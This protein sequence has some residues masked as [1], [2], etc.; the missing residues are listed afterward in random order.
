LDVLV[1]RL[2]ESSWLLTYEG[3]VNLGD[4]S[5]YCSIR[6]TATGDTD[7]I[8]HAPPSGTY[9]DEPLEGFGVELPLPNY[10]L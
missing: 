9:C 3:W 2:D 5:E 10:G 4:G 7:G 8:L 1:E 6:A